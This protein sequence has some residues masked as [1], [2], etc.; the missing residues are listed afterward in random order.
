MLADV[1]F[2]RDLE[3]PDVR[4]LDA[5]RVRDGGLVLRYE[6]LGH[7][8]PLAVRLLGGT[9]LTWTQ[10]LHVRGGEGGR[11][12]LRADAGPP[13]MHGRAEF[14]LAAAG[15]GSTRV[16]QGELVVAVPVVGA[17]AERR[18]VPGVL[19]RLDV[20]AEAVRRRLARR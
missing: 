6:Y 17:V 14:R 9:R 18:I 11:L 7:L 16:L 5:Q 10:E 19:Q 20:E 15:D 4:L 2:Y 8:D 1:A 3:L 13:L 12:E